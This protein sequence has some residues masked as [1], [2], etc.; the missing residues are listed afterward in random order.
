MFVETQKDGVEPQRSSFKRKN[1]NNYRNCP[2]K[3]RPVNVALEEDVVQP[4]SFQPTIKGKNRHFFAKNS[5]F[6]SLTKKKKT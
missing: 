5:K 1:N 4:R 6:Q 2:L 3:K